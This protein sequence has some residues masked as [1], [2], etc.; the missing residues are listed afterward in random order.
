MSYE[1]K[2]YIATGSIFVRMV[3]AIIDGVAEKVDSN[4]SVCSLTFKLIFRATFLRHNTTNTSRLRQVKINPITIIKYDSP[5][6][7]TSSGAQLCTP[8]PENGPKIKIKIV[9]RPRH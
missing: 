3:T 5:N 7:T 2:N 8:Q 4:A 9:I 6:E 1:E